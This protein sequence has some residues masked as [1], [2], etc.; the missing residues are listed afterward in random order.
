MN[1]CAD[2]EARWTKNVGLLSYSAVDAEGGYTKVVSVAPANEFEV[3]KLEGIVEAVNEARGQASQGLLANKGHHSVAN[4]EML[5]GRGIVDF[6]QYKVSRNTPLKAW[7]KRF[8]ALVAKVRLKME[9]SYGTMKRHSHIHRAR[10]SGL[11]KVEAQMVWAALGMNLLMAH[12]EIE[13]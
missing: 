12:R 11:V 8:N 13:N 9:Q 10:Y 4:R 2:D 1:W 5:K 7:H 3:N 6:I